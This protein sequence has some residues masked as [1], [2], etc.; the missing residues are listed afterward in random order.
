MLID[1]KA[2]PTIV[3]WMDNWLSDWAIETW[4]DERSTSVTLVNCKETGFP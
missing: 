2:H 1:S 3:R 4:I